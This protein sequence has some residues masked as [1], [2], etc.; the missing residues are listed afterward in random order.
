MKRL[1]TIVLFTAAVALGGWWWM[2]GR[3]SA[4][5]TGASTGASTGAGGERRPPVPVLTRPV[6]TGP[7]PERFVT[8]GTVQPLATVAVKSRVESVVDTVHF[9]EGQE[10]RAGDP[11]FTL[12]GRALEAA[13]RQAEANL[14]RDQAQ[15]VKA[16]GDVV[17]YS[18]LVQRDAIARQ[19]ND[20]AIATAAALEGTVKADRA[21]IESARV[22]LGYV[23]IVAPM[24]AR[25]G[26]VTARPGA[27]VRPADTAPLVVLTQL[28]PISVA[29]SV[30]ERFLPAIRAAMATGPLTV[31]AQAAGQTA[32]DGRGPAEGELTFVDSQVDTQTGTIL[33][34]GQFANADT[35]LWPG[36]F[37]DVVLVL[38]IEPHA[39]T[40]PADAVQIGQQGRF[41]FVVKPDQTAEVRPVTVARTADGLAVIAR[42][43]VAGERV[44]V[45]GQSRLVPG[46][47]V[48]E[49]GDKPAS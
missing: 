41:V 12:D 42:G 19:Q 14:E 45:D 36:Q 5:N 2:G 37:V 1:L 40:V 20:A 18:Q 48:V 13:L 17:R 21:A 39:L 8:I 22:G 30:P 35:H 26:T 16:R 31:I 43:L 6:E 24:A 9:T 46:F 38:R 15:L 11:L 23:R 25:T 29:F 47:R 10:V 7:V 32:G 34:K 4:A 28:R 44:V 3:G 27:M 33:A 49:R